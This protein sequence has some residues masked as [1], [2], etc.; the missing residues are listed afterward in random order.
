MKYNQIQHINPILFAIALTVLISACGSSSTKEDA[1][2]QAIQSNRITLSDEQ[3]RNAGIETGKA[4]EREISEVLQLN[5][6]VEVPVQNLI[7]VSVPFGGY[8]KSTPL[9][10]GMTVKKGE[11]IAILEDQQYIQLQQDY[12]TAKAQFAF[13]ESEFKRQKDLNESQAIS[14]KVFEQ[15]KANYESQRVLMKSL[16]QKLKLISINPEN[17]S[18]DNISRSINIYA[19]VNGFVS[20]VNVNIGKYINPSD[21]IFELIAPDDIH[22]MLTVYEQDVNKL[23]VGQKLYAYTNN[24]PDKKYLCEIILIS[25]NIDNRNAAEVHCHFEQYDVRLLPG[26]FM[27]AMVEISAGKVPSLPEEAV[28]RFDNKYYVFLSKGNNAYEMH[29]VNPGST[30]NGFIALPHA[31]ELI[32]ETIVIK[33]AYNLLMAIKNKGEQ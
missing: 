19:P 31:S 4:E 32:N 6:K 30:E 26:T 20:S 2:D 18:A 22:L 25:R 8:L 29:E 13:L 3:I 33:G 27:T 14:D 23:L 24:Q 1:S 15:T 12:L 10:S 16:E 28:V 5:G 17:L 11:M 9:L 7:S 21:V